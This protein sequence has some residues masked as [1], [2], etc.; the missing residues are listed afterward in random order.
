MEIQCNFFKPYTYYIFQNQLDVGRQVNK[1]LPTCTD[2]SSQHFTNIQPVQTTSCQ[3]RQQQPQ[4][5]RNQ[6]QLK[7]MQALRVA[8]VVVVVQQVQ[9]MTFP[10]PTQVL[11]IQLQLLNLVMICRGL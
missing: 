8:V 6:F 3:Q 7:A 2:I 1:K 5:T 10:L 11:R 4:I 9:A